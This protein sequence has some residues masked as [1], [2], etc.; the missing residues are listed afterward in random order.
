[1]DREQF[2]TKLASLRMAP[3][4]G[5]ERYPHKPLLL[6]W[7]LG[8]MQQQVTSACTYEEAEKPVS[9][10]LDDFGPPSASRHRPSR[11]SLVHG[12]GEP[13]LSEGVFR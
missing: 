13:K 5:G 1:M 8:R 4:G 12:Q 9:R 2:L 3:R 7:L 6:L 11:D 10:L